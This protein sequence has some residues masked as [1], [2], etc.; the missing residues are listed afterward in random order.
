LFAGV[1]GATVAL[2]MIATSAQAQRVVPLTSEMSDE[3]MADLAAAPAA[4]IISVALNKAQIITLSEPIRD[5]IVASP[6]IADVIVKTPRQVY[7]VSRGTGQTNMFFVG[8]NGNVVRHVVVHVMADL[9]AAHKA[10]NE[11]LPGSNITLHSVNRNVV[12]SGTVRSAAESVNALSLVS[13]FVEFEGDDGED[14]VINMLRVTE[15][16]QVLLQVRVGEISRNTLKTLGFDTDFTKTFQSGS[17]GLIGEVLGAGA[18]AESIASGTFLINEFG[19]GTADFEALERQGL[20]KTL[21]EPVLTAISGETATFLAGGEFPTPSG[22]DR[23]GNLSFEFKPFGVSL[24][25]TPVVLSGGQIS[26]RVGVEVSATTSENS[27]TVG[28]GGSQTEIPGL[29][30]RR[31]ESTVTVPSGGTL[32]I[33]GMVQN[34]ELNSISGLPGAMSLPIIGALFRSQRYQSRQ[35]ELVVLVTA[36]RVKSMGP[37]QMAALPTDGFVTASEADI[38]LYGRLHKRYNGQGS[39]GD[40]PSIYG[41]FGYIME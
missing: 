34:D 27:I 41:P 36:H 9:E 15:D 22:I 23:N 25:F 12:M 18:V 1:L 8:L 39:I 3:M 2:A 20:V 33:A 40:L 14:S 10:L 24:G 28:Q 38:Y 32:M 30:V 31:T 29:N 26:L 4:E 13:R 37:Q 21:A 19:L 6:D 16:Q 17:K 5:V 11:L 35:T 7:V